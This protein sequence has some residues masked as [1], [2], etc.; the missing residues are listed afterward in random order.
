MVELPS[1][2]Q[3]PITSRVAPFLAV[4]G[5]SGSGK[6][7]ITNLLTGR[8]DA[9][10]LHMLPKPLSTMSG[11]VNDH[12]GTLTQW[13]FYLAGALDAGDTVRHTL[14]SAPMV[15]DRWVNSVIANHTAVNSLDL[16]TVREMFAPFLRY[17]PVPDLTI[18]LETSEEE[19]LRRFHS[20]PDRTPQD[21]LLVRRP[22]LLTTVMDYYRRLA[23]EDPTAVTITTD[24]HTPE[25]LTEQI[26]LLLE[27]RRVA[28]C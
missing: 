3:P 23:A 21:R 27:T 17:L 11:Y 22:G 5:I 12:G 24:G 28:A 16:N 19:L 13:A 18:Y 8:L 7:T 10:Y 26:A 6:S 2:Y 4:E 20:R 15:T 9:S 25:E 1:C 14:A